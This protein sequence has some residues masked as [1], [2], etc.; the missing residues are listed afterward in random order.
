MDVEFLEEVGVTEEVKFLV[1]YYTYL[2]HILV[3]NFMF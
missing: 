2:I 3:F 1:L